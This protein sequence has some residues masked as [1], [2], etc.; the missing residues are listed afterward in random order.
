MSN[1][2]Y[3][4]SIY[5]TISGKFVDVAVTKELYDVYRR[6]TWNMEKRD[7][8]FKAHEIQM[9]CLDWEDGE[10]REYPS[11]ELTPLQL[12]ENTE[13]IFELYEALGMLETREVELIRAIYFA[14]K[15][16]REF[17]AER[18]ESQQSISAKKFRIFKKIRDFFKK[19]L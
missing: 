19:Q 15:T 2:K 4:L 10:T 11:N 12:V 14:G 18:G 13:T 3:T 6:M 1:N 8:A 5:D 9:S 17:G 16:Q 7:Q